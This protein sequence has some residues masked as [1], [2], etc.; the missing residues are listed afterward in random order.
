MKNFALFFV[1]TLAFISCKSAESQQAAN[2]NIRTK[3]NSN[4]V[5]VTATVKKSLEDLTEKQKQKLDKR[6]PPEVR[7]ILDK[8]DEINIYYDVDEKTMKLRVFMFE[9]KPNAC[10]KVSDP[11]LKKE[12]LESLYHDAAPN[13]NTASACFSPRHRVTAK[14]KTKTVEI[15]I[16]Y[17]CN[18]FRGESSAGSFGGDLAYPSKSSAVVDAIIEKYGAK[19]K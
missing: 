6:I 3:S 16:C 17:E 7:E 14:Y 2:S 15:D 10:A 1:F 9:T 19:I 12:F 11:S 13:S 4:L 5:E 8:A 18:N